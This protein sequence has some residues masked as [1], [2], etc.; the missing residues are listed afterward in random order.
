MANKAVPAD[1]LLTTLSD[2]AF[3]GQVAFLAECAAAVEFGPDAVSPPIAARKH[4]PAGF[5]YFIGGERGPI[6]IGHACDPYTRLRTLQTAY[7]EDLFIYATLEGCQADERSL[8]LE[9]AEFRLRGE[10][11]ER[12]A[13]I[14]RRI[15]HLQNEASPNP[16]HSHTE[17]AA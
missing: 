3:H 12:S 7:P 5:V 2:A 16:S 13:P 1:H 6:K 9:F 17:G 15:I 4:R 11:F 10:W 8:H 14:L